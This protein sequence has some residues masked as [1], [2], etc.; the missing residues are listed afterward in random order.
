MSSFIKIYT[1]FLGEFRNYA[2]EWPRAR[3]ARG[4]K[5]IRAEVCSSVRGAAVGV[6][7]TNQELNLVRSKQACAIKSCTKFVQS[8]SCMA[9]INLVPGYR[10]LQLYNVR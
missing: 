7:Y 9:V 2:T 10:S 5:R 4:N 1:G 3:T 8:H 6:K